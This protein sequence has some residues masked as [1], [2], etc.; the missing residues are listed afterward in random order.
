VRILIDGFPC[1]SGLE[2]YIWLDD[3]PIISD[4]AGWQGCHSPVL[5]SRTVIDGGIHQA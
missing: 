5:H 3:R 4:A 1:C 2:L